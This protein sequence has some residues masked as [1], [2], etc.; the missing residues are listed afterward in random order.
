ML[1][2]INVHTHVH[3]LAHKNACVYTHKSLPEFSLRLSHHRS[4]GLPDPGTMASKESRKEALG[5][6]R[7]IFMRDRPCPLLLEALQGSKIER[8]AT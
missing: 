8:R 6:G 5:E 2:H 4:L 7:N 1:T 3:M